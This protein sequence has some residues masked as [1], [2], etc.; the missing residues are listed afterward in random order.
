MGQLKQLAL[1]AATAVSAS[2]VDKAD[3]WKAQKGGDLESNSA[4]LPPEWASLNSANDTSAEFAFASVQASS[5]V[6]LGTGNSCAAAGMTA[7]AT[8]SGSF[9]KVLGVSNPDHCQRLCASAKPCGAAVFDITEKSCEMLKYV[10]GLEKNANRTVVLPDCETGCFEQNKTRSSEDGKLLGTAPNANIC[11]SMCQADANCSKFAWT[12]ANN[13]CY[14]SG[15]TTKS[16]VGGVVGPKDSCSPNKAQAGYAGN[17]RVYGT[18]TG[19]DFDVVRNVNSYEDCQS[20]CINDAKCQWFTYNSID[21]VCYKKAERAG[22]MLG[23]SGDETSPKYTDSSCFVRD[24]ILTDKELS[25]IS[26]VEH[27]QRCR[28]ECVMNANCNLW[29]YNASTKLCKLF[30][31]TS[32]A[33]GRYMAD[34]WTGTPYACG[35]GLFLYRE[36]ATN[37]A[38]R[39]VKYGRTGFI[40][41]E[42]SHAEDCQARCAATPRCQA[43]AFEVLPRKCHLHTAYAEQVKTDDGNFI[44][45]SKWCVSCYTANSEYSAIPMKEITAGIGTQN[46]CQLRC[47]ATPDCH[48][49]S[50]APGGSCKLMQTDGSAKTTAGAFRAP[51][52]CGW[53]CEMEGFDAPSPAF[54]WIKTVSNKDRD[55]CRRECQ[56][57]KE[58]KTYVQMQSG[59]C[60][61]KDETA[62]RNLAPKETGITGFSTCS[63]CFKYGEGYIVGDNELW[64]LEAQTP[65][66]CRLRCETM[67]EC[68]YFTF[69]ADGKKCSLLSGDIGTEQKDHVVSGPARCDT[70]VTSCFLTNVVWSGNDNIYQ[71]SNTSPEDCQKL[72]AKNR[73]C[74]FFTVSH[75]KICFLK[76]GQDGTPITTEARKKW[77]SGPKKCIQTIAGCTEGKYDY[78]KSNIYGSAKK[79]NSASQCQQWCYDEPQ[80]R[81]WTHY[82]ANNACWLKTISAFNDRTLTNG[83]ESGARLGCPKCLRAGVAYNG[84]EVRRTS[85]VGELQCQLICELND[86]CKFFSYYSNGA[87]ILMSS[88]GKPTESVT[89]TISGPR[90][91]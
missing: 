25:E 55:S 83:A 48:Y 74:R 18:A 58:C 9:L 60:Y 87:C 26:S 53:A 62:L 76:T 34:T 31:N 15:G 38:R 16:Y 88:M 10:A 85:A 32:V 5:T 7:N 69:N 71:Q 51:K 20:A 59:N 82:Q 66:E 63:A 84:T 41:E 12:S 47:Q 3:A 72:C 39:G 8:D 89:S 14:S 17:G 70:P 86:K 24:V 29:T 49:W 23:K 44:S 50:Y 40:V 19:D 91:C 67:E 81:V 36:R 33:N 68:T 79:T 61:L 13:E 75:D 90:K 52:H 73:R 57:T 30:S 21:K 56:A 78:A 43:W 46:E 45:G 35:S 64:T 54:G 27:A 4:F 11:R 28:Y 42:T 37:C 1:L 77:V 6:A 80:C 2:L 22:F 65:E